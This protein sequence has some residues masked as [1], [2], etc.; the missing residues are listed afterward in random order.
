MMA[1]FYTF[2]RMLLLQW[3][4]FMGSCLKGGS[5]AW[6]KRAMLSLAPLVA[7]LTALALLLPIRPIKIL[8]HS[9]PS[10][11]EPE[12]VFRKLAAAHHEGIRPTGIAIKL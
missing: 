3:S 12:K 10:L 4:P 6:N 2:L 8:A 9:K 1:V 11:L 5:H 7:L